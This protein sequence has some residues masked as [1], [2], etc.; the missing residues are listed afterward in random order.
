MSDGS[1]DGSSMSDKDQT[2]DSDGNSLAEERTT[3][4]EDRTDWAEDR[5]AMANERT[6]AGWMRTAFAAIGIG[7]GFNALFDKLEPV[8]IPKLI[9][10][11]FICIGIVVMYSAQQRACGAFERLSA[12][13]VEK[14][15]VIRLRLLSWLVIVGS[16]CLIGAFWLLTEPE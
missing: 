5:T 6:F 14:P 16:L 13:A 2:Q 9:A 10:S 1:D 4:A 7:I 3:Y 15:G 11:G 8:W 12:H